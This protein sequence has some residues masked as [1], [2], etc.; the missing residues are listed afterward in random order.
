MKRLAGKVALI[1]GASRG[2]GLALARRFAAE[3][4]ALIICARGQQA[5]QA[6][7]AELRASGARVLALQGDAADPRDV[8]RLVALTLKEHGRIDVLINNAGIL[9]P[10]PMPLL[11]DY[12][13]EAFLEVLRINTFGPFLLTQKVLSAMLQH[14]RGSIINVTSEAG[15]VGYAGWGAYGAS[16]FALEGLSQTWAAE[17]E[18]TGVRLNWIDPGSIDTEMQALANPEPEEALPQPE[19]VTEL[20]V[21]LAGDAAL[22]VHG[23]RFRAQEVTAL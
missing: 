7:A 8:E 19:T 1:T 6:A 11:V 18:G 15:A 22:G 2:L 21:Q 16:K 14:G 10:S 9:G 13:P 20:F 23:R 5:L 17:L 3:G 4:A 12:P